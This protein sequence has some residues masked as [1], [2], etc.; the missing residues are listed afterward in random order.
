MNSWHP[1]FMG[2]LGRVRREISL[3]KQGRK[4]PSCYEDLICMPSSGVLRY[5]SECPVWRSAILGPKIL[6]DPERSKSSTNLR[7]TV[8]KCPV[9]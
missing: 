9:P 1:I 8:G 5:D 4:A 2:T 6:P 7:L 3:Q